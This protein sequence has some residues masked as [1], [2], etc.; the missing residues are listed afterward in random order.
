MGIRD[1]RLNKIINR[2]LREELQKGNLPSSKEFMWRLSSYLNQHNLN[3]PEYHFKSVRRGT[4]ALSSGYNKAID[5][6]YADLEALYES[7]I[8][9]HNHIGKN[10]S[11]FD[12]DKSKIEYEINILE[13]K[14]R[15]MILM[16]AKSGF[17]SSVFDVFDDMKKVDVTHSTVNVD[18]KNNEVTIPDMKNTS[19]RIVPEATVGFQLLDEIAKKV[20][21][22]TISGKPSNALSDNINETWQHLITSSTER[23]VAGYYY[24]KFKDKQA[25]NRISLSLQSI[26]PTHVRIEFTPDNLNWF[27]LPYFEEGKMMLNDYTFDFPSLDMQQMRILMRKDEPDVDSM[28]NGKES[29]NSFILGI[30][31]IKMF[32]LDFAEEGILYSTP[33]EVEIPKGQNFSVNKVSL[34][35]EEFLPN[36]TDIEYSIALPVPEGR[37]PEWKKISP[38]NR[39]NPKNEQVIDFKNIT[40]APA[41]KFTIDPTLSVGEYE[42]ISLY[43]NGINFYKIGAV[44]SNKKIIAGTERLFA[45]R[46]SW[47][48]KSFPGSYSEGDKHIPSLE[49]WSKPLGSIQYGYAKIEDGRPGSIMSG[50]SLTEAT[51]FMYTLGVFS[52][53]K[54][55]V[56][57]S[58]PASTDPIAIYMNGEKVFEGMSS[59]STRINYL[60]KNG[61][62]EIVVLVYV[63]TP[64]TNGSSVD[65]GFDPRSYGANIY[66]Q[67]KP[68][69]RVSLADLRFNVKSNDRGK[70]S[71]TEINDEQVVVLN[72]IVPGLDY[73]FYFH[74][75]EGDV[76]DS[77]L[78]KAEL[79]RDRDVTNVSPKLQKYY[80]RFS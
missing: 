36:G 60:F 58:I 14:L 32:Q 12:V 52:E 38:V 20:D 22:A 18:T 54:E 44:P 73:D 71:I 11:K 40:R 21:A 66:S 47:Q 28:S 51:S 2:I 29:D 57:S 53:K 31:Q 77:I 45:G 13:N 63:N 26:K 3:R 69:E 9:L 72:H 24:I 75:V 37:E 76:K 62:N 42:M 59:A 35:T 1:K 50:Q 30:K 41:M 78:F 17:L 80:L 15:E 8:E 64:K 49:D 19:I 23:S 27:T 10:L 67:A 34:L 79:K 68:L 39:N 5:T 55:E 61:W 46:N 7:T 6:V 65:L 25:L 56:A 4:K 70:Y 16:Y 33:L 48:V 43:S 74:Q